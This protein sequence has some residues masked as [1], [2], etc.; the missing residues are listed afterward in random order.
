MAGRTDTTRYTSVAMA[1]H[2]V[3]ALCI[4]GLIIFGLLM[5]QEWMPNR[6]MIYQMHKS[7]G[8]LV[9]I[10]SVLRLIWRLMHKPPALPDAMPGWQKAASHVT[11]WA[12][13]GL[14]FVVPL[15]GWAM[16]SASTLPVPTVL[17]WLVPLPDM[18]GVSESD[19]LADQFKAL[20][21]I[22]AKLFI[23]LI[24]LHVGAALKHQ[25]VDRDGVLL[26]MM[27]K[28]LRRVR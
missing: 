27:P 15:L 22:G 11:H 18:P 26:R 23:A 4:I 16:V 12:F 8:I 25:F 2:W 17:F 20:H 6:F 3:I 9:L 24:I 14:M 1:L 21:E 10:L 7:L 5:T 13:Y 19:A 28:G